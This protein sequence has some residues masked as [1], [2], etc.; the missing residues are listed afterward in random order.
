M[1]KL[2]AYIKSIKL[3]NVFSN[4]LV[5]FVGYFII[6]TYQ[7]WDTPE[8]E[9]PQLRGIEVASSQMVSLDDFEK[10]V[11]V[12]F[13]ATWCK[14]CQ[15]EHSSIKSIAEDYPVLSIASQS[16]GKSQVSAFIKENQ[17]NFPVILDNDGE[18]FSQWGGVGYPT[19]FIINKDNTVEYVEAGFTTEMGLR[20]RLMLASLW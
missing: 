11:L 10:P 13:W 3:K 16:G 20:L 12:H 14:I 8:G 6:H 7:T 2:I 18:M 5:L 19:S 4:L 15:F 17:I 1:G 9:V